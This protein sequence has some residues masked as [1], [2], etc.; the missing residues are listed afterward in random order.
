MISNSFLYKLDKASN[1]CKNDVN[2][3]VKIAA[4]VSPAVSL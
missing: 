1:G 4:R 3:V 2:V